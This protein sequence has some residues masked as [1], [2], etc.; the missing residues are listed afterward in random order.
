MSDESEIHPVDAAPA[1]IAPVPVALEVTAPVGASAQHSVLNS[2]EAEL[3]S[4]W[5]DFRNRLKSLR[6]RL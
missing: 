4:L 1:D 2:V 3:E 6:A 5:Q